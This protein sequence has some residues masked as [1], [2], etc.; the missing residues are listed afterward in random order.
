MP[1]DS[2]H[3]GF[4]D[5]PPDV[6]SLRLCQPMEDPEPDDGEWELF[7]PDDDEAY[8]EPGDFWIEDDDWEDAA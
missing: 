7:S 2:R 3:E 4:A 6:A 5:P 1:A 8:P